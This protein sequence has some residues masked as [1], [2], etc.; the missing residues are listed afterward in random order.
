MATVFNEAGQAVSS[1]IAPTLPLNNATREEIS[2]DGMP[3]ISRS[4]VGFQNGI[5]FFEFKTTTG[6]SV[7]FTITPD[8]LLLLATASMEV[9]N[10]RL[11]FVLT[12]I[13]L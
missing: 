12:A 4:I 3:E 1:S 5:G 7:R 8:K 11:G 9:V 13:G 6:N 2:D 10:Q